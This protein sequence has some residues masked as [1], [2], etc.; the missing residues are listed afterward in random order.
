MGISYRKAQK[1]ALGMGLYQ[2]ETKKTAEDAAA[3]EEGTCLAAEAA[4][5][6]ED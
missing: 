5:E 4:W 2:D 6:G 3:E 1:M